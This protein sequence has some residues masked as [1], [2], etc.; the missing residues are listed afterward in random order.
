MC[1][2]RFR[3][4]VEVSTINGERTL[5]DFIITVGD[6]WHAFEATKVECNSMKKSPL[7]RVSEHIFCRSPKR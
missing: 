1:Q 3:V 4:H 7:E 6:N 5:S 2:G